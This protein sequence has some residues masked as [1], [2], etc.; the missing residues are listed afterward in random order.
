MA[1]LYAIVYPTHSAAESAFET[2]KGLESAGYLTVLEQA[3]VRKSDDGDVSVDEEKHPVRRG[4]VAGGVL[5]AI[6]GT[7][8]LAPVA[9]AAAGAAIGGLIGKG[10]KSGGGDDFKEFSK[11]VQQEMPNGSAAIVVLGQTD[12]RDRVIFNLGGHGGKVYSYDISEEALAA[13]QREV[14]RASG[15]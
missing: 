10:E 4:V 8:F 12:A 13:V 7:M 9:G 6:A 5:G 3:L 2:V 15:A 14:D 11:T 1:G